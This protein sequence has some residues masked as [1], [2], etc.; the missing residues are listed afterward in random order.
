MK[1]LLIG[2]VV[3]WTIGWMVGDY[4][5]KPLKCPKNLICI[6]PIINTINPL[7]EWNK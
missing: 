1:Y 6:E 3:G 4:F 7:Y 5:S 2:L